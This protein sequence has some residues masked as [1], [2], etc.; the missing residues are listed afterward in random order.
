M[1]HKINQKENNTETHEQWT[2][3]RTLGIVTQHAE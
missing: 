3:N 2:I 1:S